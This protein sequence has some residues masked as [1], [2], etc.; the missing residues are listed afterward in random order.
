MQTDAVKYDISFGF[1]N[2]T[3][4]TIPGDVIKGTTTLD[5]S[6]VHVMSIDYEKDNWITIHALIPDE[7]VSDQPLFNGG[8]VADIIMTGPDRAQTAHM[9]TIAIKTYPT[10]TAQ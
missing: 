9:G 8:Q 3:K 2:A 5:M 6:Q 4:F 7:E 1:N 10:I